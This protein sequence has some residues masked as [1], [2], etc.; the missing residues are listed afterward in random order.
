MNIF[1]AIR[2]FKNFQEAIEEIKKELREER[3]I[4]EK[5]G[6]KIVF[7]GMGEILSIEFKEKQ[8]CEKV[9]KTLTELINQ[10]QDKA[11]DKVKEALNKRF[12]GFPGGFGFEI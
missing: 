2:Q 4:L 3:K 10:A 11:R 6:I 1:E 9:G 5:E 8:N 7:N 12:G